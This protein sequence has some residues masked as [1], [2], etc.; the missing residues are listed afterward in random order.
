MEISWLLV[1]DWPDLELSIELDPPLPLLLDDVLM[2]DDFVGPISLQ[3]FLDRPLLK[4]LLKDS[5]DKVEDSEEDDERVNWTLYG[6]PFL[7]NCL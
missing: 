7:F 5:D 2:A 4:V 6:E 1:D 3:S